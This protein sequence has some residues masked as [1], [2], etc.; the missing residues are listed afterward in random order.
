MAICFATHN[1]NKVNEINRLIENFDVISL[2]DIGIEEDIEETGTSLEE[3]ALIKAQHVFNKTGISCFADDTGLEVNALKGAP[4]VYSAR[5]AGEPANSEKNIDKLLKN[6]KGEEN[7]KARFRT[8]IAFIKDGNPIFFEGI[9][10]GEI[11]EER[12]GENG[13][14]YDSVFL[15]I[16]FDR[17][18]AEMDMAEKNKIS[19]R[20]MAVK[21]LIEFLNKE[22]S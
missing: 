19:H 13:F 20:G 10:K 4:G 18:F 6:L 15:P 22:Q 7:R 1:Q 8:V 17:T 14:G 16:N 12:R 2:D 9:I 3:N 11:I 21:K 5:Y